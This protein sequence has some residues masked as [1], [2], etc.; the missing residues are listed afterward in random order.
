MGRGLLYSR[1]SYHRFIKNTEL[2]TLSEQTTHNSKTIIVTAESGATNRTWFGI[3]PDGNDGVLGRVNAI[4]V[5]V[6]SLEAIGGNQALYQLNHRTG[7]LSS[8]NAQTIDPKQPE[9][10]NNGQYKCISY[11][12][13]GGVVLLEITLEW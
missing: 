9:T 10:F 11:E 1:L 7:D 3:D 13:V 6:K 2:I 5:K 4:N 12:G 8:S